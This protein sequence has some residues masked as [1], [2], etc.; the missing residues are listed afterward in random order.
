MR[1]IVTRGAQVARLFLILAFIAV[2]APPRHATAAASPN[3]VT[4]ST[5]DD[6]TA[7]CWAHGAMH[8]VR[9]PDVNA[10]RRSGQQPPASRLYSRHYFGAAAE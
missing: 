8:S 7:E 10:C 5:L 3:D 4:N 6:S 2:A 1:M 9:V